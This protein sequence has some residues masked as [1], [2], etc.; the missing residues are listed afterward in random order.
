MGLYTA[1][2]EASAPSSPSAGNSVL[3]PLTADARWYYKTA[4]GTV[5]ALYADGD[6]LGTPAS[7]TLTS[8]TGLPVSSGI[9]GLGT[10]VATALAVN[11]G[12]AGAPITFNGAMGTPSSGTV[13][14]LTGTASININGT[15]GATTA[16]T[17]AFTTLSAAGATTILKNGGTGATAGLLLNGG[18]SGTT[19]NVDY[20]QPASRLYMRQTYTD[21][22]GNVTYQYSS[23]GTMGTPIDVLNILWGGGITVN[24]ATT[25]YGGTVAT[26]NFKTAAASWTLGL[27]NSNATTC[28]GLGIKYTAATPNAAGSEFAYWEDA[29]ALRFSVKS[30]GGINNYS[31]NN[32]NLSDERR[33]KQIVAIDLN[34]AWTKNKALQYVT[35]LY[36]DQTD[37]I[38]NHGLVAQQVESVA[39]EFVDVSGFGETPEDGVP[40][41]GLWETD[42]FYM[43]GAVLQKAQLR[44]EELEARLSRLEAPKTE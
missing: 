28:Y 13:T 4:A 26:S 9:S 6:A 34:D 33:K 8:C 40:L 21:G 1:S 27:N 19:F 16:T 41:K 7:G 24:G 29:T 30:N 43:L 36:K 32:T 22:S 35:Y 12:S 5:K 14:N 38:L 15:V 44:I 42:I 37:A 20:G 18:G 3:Y 17:G 31:A 10:G 39:P 2:L 11:V 23:D 25:G